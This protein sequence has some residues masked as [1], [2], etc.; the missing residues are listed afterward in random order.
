MSYDLLRVYGLVGVYRMIHDAVVQQGDYKPLEKIW[1]EMGMNEVETLLQT[2]DSVGQTACQ[3]MDG[4]LNGALNGAFG[5]G[6]YRILAKVGRFQDSESL[7]NET[8]F[9]RHSSLSAGGLGI[10]VDEL[11]DPLVSSTED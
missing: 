1:R 10:D 6:V 4:A 9:F 5:E 11:R 3:Q 7:V 2:K 8:N